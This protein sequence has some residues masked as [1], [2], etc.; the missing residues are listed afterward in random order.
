MTSSADPYVQSSSMLGVRPGWPKRLLHVV[1]A[2]SPLVAALLV[3]LPLCP[4]AAMFGIPCPGC[5]LTRATLAAFHGHFADAFHLHPLFLFVTP[6]YLGVIGS[7]GWTYIRGSGY[8]PSRR[9]DK[10]I[11]ALAL[12]AFVLL[13]GVWVARF[14]GAFGGPVPVEMVK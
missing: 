4:T 1:L 11:T 3:E 10:L 13:F 6:L 2:A 12:T 14:Y 9:K 5:G 8:A 7:L